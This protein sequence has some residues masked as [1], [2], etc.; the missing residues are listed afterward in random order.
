MRMKNFLRMTLSTRRR[1]EM[2]SF[3]EMKQSISHLLVCQATQSIQTWFHI[4]LATLHLPSSPYFPSWWMAWMVARQND[5]MPDG[6]GRNSFL[7]SRLDSISSHTTHTLPLTL[8]SSWA[9]PSTICLMWEVGSCWSFILLP[10]TDQKYSITVSLVPFLSFFLTSCLRVSPMRDERGKIDES[11][12]HWDTQPTGE[13]E[14][15]CPSFRFFHFLVLLERVFICSFVHLY[16]V[17]FYFLLSSF[18][19]HSPHLFVSSSS[20]KPTRLPESTK[21]DFFS[22]YSLRPPDDMMIWEYNL[23]NQGGPLFLRWEELK[24]VKNKQTIIKT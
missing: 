22:P 11:A 23:G 16:F 9:I 19:P 13:R 15:L 12:T 8:S 1:M 10:V 14:D 4:S 6:M 21:A 20:T 18:S 24:I 2:V 3:W 17:H 5:D 7:T